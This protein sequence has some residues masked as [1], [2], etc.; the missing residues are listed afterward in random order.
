M[1][2]LMFAQ[3]LGICLNV[4]RFSHTLKKNDLL[5]DIN[6]ACDPC[7]AA[8]LLAITGTLEL[9]KKQVDKIKYK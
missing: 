4:R 3:E 6:V 5:C 8:A 9:L 7:Q 1:A 2:I